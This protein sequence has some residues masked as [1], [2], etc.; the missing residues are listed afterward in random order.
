MSSAREDILDA[1]RRARGRGPLASPTRATLDALIA[2]PVRHLRPLF[3]EDLTARFIRKLESRSGTVARVTGR[4]QVPD[5]VE[6]FRSA[7]DIA[8]RAAVGAGLSDLVWPADWIIHHDRAGIEETLSVSPAFAGI[9]ETGTLMLLASPDS[10]TTHNFVPD[11]Q[12]VI[13]ET[14]RILRHFEDA[15]AALRERTDG[16]PRAVNLVS[17]PS[18]T[19]DIEQTIQLG[20]HGPRRLHV[21]LVD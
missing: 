21:V 15:W 16:M 17:G 18:R 2:T 12:V 3:D 14:T 13:L 7:H 1:V 6:T 8:A 11:N 9:A 4:A 20:A 10:P 5:A 19:A